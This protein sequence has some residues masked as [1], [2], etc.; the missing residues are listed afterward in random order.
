[1]VASMPHTVWPVT[2]VGL[3]VPPSVLAQLGSNV[4]FPMHSW[5]FPQVF[6]QL[7]CCVQTGHR[8]GSLK[9]AAVHVGSRRMGWLT[10]GTVQQPKQSHPFGVRDWQL[11]THFTDCVAGQLWNVGS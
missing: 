5:H 7:V 4:V 1:M 11:C 10:P 3:G 6:M 9:L 8:L 2:Q